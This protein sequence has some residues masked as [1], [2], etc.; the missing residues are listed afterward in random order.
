METRMISVPNLNR[1][2]EVEAIATTAGAWVGAAVTA[3]IGG[4]LT[5]AIGLFNGAKLGATI[6]HADANEVQVPIKDT[7]IT[8]K[9]QFAFVNGKLHTVDPNTGATQEVIKG[10]FQANPTE[11]LVPQ[12]LQSH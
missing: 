1:N 9:A 7:S 6:T 10:Q 3:G 8:A 11:R 12:H 5:G 4:L 2:Q